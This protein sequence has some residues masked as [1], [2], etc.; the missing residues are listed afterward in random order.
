MTVFFPDISDYEDGLSLVGAPFVV[1][2]GTQ[3]TSFTAHTYAGFKAQAAQLGIGFAAYHW[4]T[5][6]DLQAQVQHAYSVIGSVPTMWDAEAVGATVSRLVDLTGRYRALGG[7]PRA[8]YL[9]H[10][11]WQVLGSPSLTPLRDAGL[12]LISSNYPSVGYSDTGPGWAA[13]GGVSPTVWQYTDKQQFNGQA[14]DF[15]AYKGTLDQLLA[16][17]GLTGTPTPQEDPMMIATDGKAYY[18]CDGMRSRPVDPAHVKDLVYLASQ[19]LFTLAKGPGNN[20]EWTANGTVRLGWTEANM[21]PVD[22]PTT[23][24]PAPAPVTLNVSLSG[25]ATPAP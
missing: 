4:V 13:Y 5:D 1:A 21:G 23:G 17:W 7:N 14:C 18:L 3:G 9:P 16:L 15:N 10:W 19:G 22:Q 11:W 6:A 8:V 25:T 24:S 2:K 20:A 12:F